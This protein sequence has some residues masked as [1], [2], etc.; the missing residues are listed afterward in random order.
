MAEG[1]GYFAIIT[2]KTINSDSTILKFVSK[3][4]DSDSIILNSISKTIDSNS[5]IVKNVSKT[6]Y[7]DSQILNSESSTLNS[8]SHIKISQDI[9]D[10]NLNDGLV[11]HWS[12]N[13]N[14]AIHNS[15]I[16]DVVGL[17]DGTLSTSDGSTNKSVNAKVN[18]A[19]DFSLNDRVNCGTS[20]T[21]R[22]P[23][24]TVSCWIY[25]IERSGTASAAVGSSTWT[26]S[27]P[28]NGFKSGFVMRRYA[29]DTGMEFIQGAAL[30]QGSSVSTS[31]ALRT[32]THIL[33]SYDGTHLR[34]YKNGVLFNTNSA[35]FTASIQP[36]Y[37]AYDST[38][39]AYND[40]IVDDV[41]Y[42]NRV[43]TDEEVQRLFSA[44]DKALNADSYV[45]TTG[46][47]NNKTI[48]SNSHIIKSDSKTVDSDSYI[49]NILIKTIYNQ[50]YILKPAIE[51]FIDSGS[52]ILKS[53]LQSSITSNSYITTQNPKTI[54]SDYTI[55]G[56]ISGTINSDSI[57]LNSDSKTITSES[58]I[59]INVN[60]TIQSN[61]IIITTEE[62]GSLNSTSHI[63]KSID[64]TLQ[65]TSHL[66]TLNIEGSL[67]SVSHIK[68]SYDNE[69]LNT[70]LH[71][72]KSTAS[73]ITSTSIVKVLD[74]EDSISS[75]S[76]I[77][78]NTTITLDDSTDIIDSSNI[79]GHWKMNNDLT[80]S[81]GNG[82]DGT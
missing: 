15:T 56:L 18:R 8:D 34:G 22:T 40:G 26:S 59:N 44:G 50:S 45:L 29:N 19:V 9:G 64:S 35:S 30:N 28:S 48:D 46:S 6:V 27:D 4:I 81:S 33:M 12:L 16:K 55:V 58:Y 43:L 41:R 60:K 82:R 70:N 79:F 3:T 71:I 17:N 65:S 75:N 20:A 74:V 10:S 2:Q 5:Y 57:I 23:Q 47:D 62:Y 61:S 73:T 78:F 31:V 42:Y 72:L 49:A 53:E 32:W 7:S 77:T 68:S 13:E 38:N 36:F 80:D 54:D 63:I 39:A 76:H 67:L 52:Y 66:I 14:P 25:N 1:K 21:L 24:Y 37:I 11:S 69:V 51:T